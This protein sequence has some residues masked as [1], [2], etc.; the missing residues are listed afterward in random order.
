MLGLYN[1]DLA[2]SYWCI[3]RPMEEC[4]VTS[5]EAATWHFPRVG[6]VST[7]EKNLFEVVGVEPTLEKN[8]FEVVGVE[9][10]TY[11]IPTSSLNHPLYTLVLNH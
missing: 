11:R 6:L 1:G 3:F 9:P 2:R 7:L 5:P 8:L 10:M 4:H